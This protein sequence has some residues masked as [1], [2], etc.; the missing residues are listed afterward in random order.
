[1]GRAVLAAWSGERVLVVQFLKGTGYTGELSAAEHWKG[2][3]SICQFGAGC[4][5]SLEIGKGLLECERCGNCFRENRNPENN[6]AG[7]AFECAN[8][9]SLSGLWDLLVLDEISHAMNRGILETAKVVDWVRDASSRVRIVLTG[10]NM[11]PDLL[12]IAEEA[13][14]CKMLKHPMTRGIWGRRGVEY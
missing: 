14:E 7:K 10:R 1:M 6:F 9:A 2:T 8:T 11:P 3:L 5:R 13:T 12:E 4:P